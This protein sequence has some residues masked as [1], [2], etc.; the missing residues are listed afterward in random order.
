MPE[1]TIQVNT[2]GG[3]GSA[4]GTAET[5]TPVRGFVY[6]VKMD[7]NASAPATTTVQLM[8]GE[9]LNQT[10]LDLPAGN[11]DTTLYPRVQENATDGTTLTSRAVAY[12]DGHKL[13]VAVAN[14]DALTD[15]VVARVLVV[16]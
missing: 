10:I 5:A 7:Y 9:G 4:S 12:V 3:S 6:A 1:Y 2:T 15:A 8:V 11:T 16:A 14:C 13:S